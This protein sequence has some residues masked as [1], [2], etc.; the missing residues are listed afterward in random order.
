MTVQETVRQCVHERFSRH[1]LQQTAPQTV[2]WPPCRGTPINEFNTEGYIS[3]A[4]STLFPTGAADFLAPQPLAVT[5]GNYVKHLIMYKD[6]R[7]AQ[8][9]RFRYFALN[10]EMRWRALQAGRIYNIRQHP[11]DAQLSVEE[12]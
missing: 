6:A 11:H 3:C 7:F 12:L 8:H 2:S 5:A 1:R 10:T 4:F 9:P